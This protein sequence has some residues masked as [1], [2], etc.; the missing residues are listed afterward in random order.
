MSFWKS[1][2]GGA[3]GASASAND[4]HRSAPQE[5]KGFRIV[6]TPYKEAGQ[7][8]LCGV[9]SKEI[10]GETRERRFVRADRFASLDDAIAM[11]FLK[12][13]QIIDQ[14]GERLFDER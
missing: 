13:R 7:H 12:A 6:A 5:H 10:D 4:E 11:T 8:Q 2:F 14:Q 3:A 9:I 1:L